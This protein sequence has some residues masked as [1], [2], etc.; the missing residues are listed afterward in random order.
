V[1]GLWSTAG[2]WTPAGPPANGDDLAFGSG[3]QNRQMQSGVTAL[4][5]NS[6]TVD[7]VG[8]SLT[9]PLSATSLIKNGIGIFSYSGNGSGVSSTQIN[10]GSLVLDG[11]LGDVATNS[12]GTFEMRGGARASTIVGNGGRLGSETFDGQPVFVGTGGSKDFRLNGGTWSSSRSAT[13][14]FERS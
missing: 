4:A 9:G 6:V 11:S 12:G 14:K 3:G 2:N 8:Y 13:T 7:A 1:N 5:L 10:G